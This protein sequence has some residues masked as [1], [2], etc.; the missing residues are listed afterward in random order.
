MLQLYQNL[1][2]L[3]E[4]VLRYVQLHDLAIKLSL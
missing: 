1:T 3:N 4:G 2:S